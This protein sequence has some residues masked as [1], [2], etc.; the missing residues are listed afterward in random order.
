[1]EMENELGGHFDDEVDA[2]K[3][4]NQLCEEFGIPPKN[5]EISGLPSHGSKNR[6][7]KILNGVYWHKKYKKWI[8][9]FRINGKTI[10]GG[11]F[12]SKIDAAKQVNQICKECGISPKNPVVTGEPRHA[13]NKRKQNLFHGIYWHKTNKKWVAHLQVDGRNKYGGSFDNEVDAAKKVNQ[14]CQEI[15]IAPRNPEIICENVLDQSIINDSSF[16]TG[17][18]NEQ[19]FNQNKRKRSQETFLEDSEENVFTEDM[20]LQNNEF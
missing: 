5:P 8:A 17:I 12:H 13:P 15:K 3:R 6:T 16:V 10:Y 11:Y 1:M 2:A 7:K 20:L 19:N 4:V 18:K 9:T 14:M